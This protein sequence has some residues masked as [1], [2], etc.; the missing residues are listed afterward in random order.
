MTLGRLILTKNSSKLFVDGRYLIKCRHAGSIPVG[1]RGKEASF[2]KDCRV[3]GFDQDTTTYTQYAVWKKDYKMVPLILGSLRLVKD[4]YEIA[5]LRESA[6]LLRKGFSYVKRILKPGMTEK[7]VAKQFEIYCLKHGAEGFSFPTM[8]G[9]GAGSAEIHHSTG[10]A[11]LKKND[12]VLFDAG[13]IYKG[14][15]SDRTRTFEVGKAPKKMHEIKKIVVDAY[16]AGIKASIVGNTPADV[17]HAVDGVIGKYMKCYTH[18]VGHGV[19]LEVHE[20]I[21]LRREAPHKDII[22]QPGMVF[23][24]EPGIYIEGLGGVRH[25]DMVLV[26]DDG[27][28]IL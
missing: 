26:T 7:Q 16:H 20:A 10:E 3:L 1:E 11:R 28:E 22:F 27:F 13:V 6:N 24:I 25:E 12:W 5:C 8:V 19:G 23:T 9:F 18:T 4:E 17:N 14:Y 15:C 2:L 21:S